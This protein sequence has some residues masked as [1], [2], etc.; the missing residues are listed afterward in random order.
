MISCN[1]K[2]MGD[3]CN[4]VISRINLYWHLLLY[5]IT[6][7][8]ERFYVRII[9]VSLGK[10]CKFNGWTSFFRAKKSLIDIGMF[11]SF[12]SSGYKNHIGLN[13][14]CIICTHTSNAIIEVG[15]NTGMSSTTINC[16]QQI[17]IGK[18]VRIG[19]NCVIMDGDFHLD[20]FRI[21]APKPISIC[22]NVWLG[23]N[24]VVMKG[25][26][27]GENTIIGMNSV[28][29]KDIPANCVAAGNPCRF[30]KSL[31]K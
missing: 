10:K 4:S 1:S 29:T 6:T 12:N 17:K 19:A 14:R 27:I 28:V 5:V 20:D 16:W 15:E 13:H 9:G 23:A 31:P 3:F 8:S 22:D 2:S 7:Y 30:I 11:C 24:V 25:V 18:N 21:G 26:T